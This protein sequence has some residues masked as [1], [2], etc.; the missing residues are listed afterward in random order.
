MLLFQLQATAGSVTSF[1]DSLWLASVQH[2]DE[3]ACAYRLNGNTNFNTQN[4]FSEFTLLRFSWM[5]ADDVCN[6]VDDVRVRTSTQTRDAVGRSSEEGGDRGEVAES[7]EQLPRLMVAPFDYK[8]AERAEGF[9]DKL[10]NS[11]WLYC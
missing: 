4:N 8:E 6:L 5:S 11:V 10:T 7:G 9:H 2:A 1:L 3:Y